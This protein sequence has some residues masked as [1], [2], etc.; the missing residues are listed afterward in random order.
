VNGVDAGHRD[1]WRAGERMSEALRGG[2]D[3]KT[4]NG[5][6]LHVNN[7]RVSPVVNHH[8]HIEVHGSVRSDRD[9]RDVVLQ[10]MQRYGGRNSTTW[11]QFKR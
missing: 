4:M 5:A 9:L 11:Q 6:N 10:E 8:V 7:G 1:V 2:H 3:V